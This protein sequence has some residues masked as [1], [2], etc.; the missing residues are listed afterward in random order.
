MSQIGDQQSHWNGQ[1]VT[2]VHDENNGEICPVLTAIGIYLHLMCIDQ[3]DGPLMVA[4]LDKDK[5][6]GY[7]TA[8]KIATMLRK[9][10]RNIHPDLLEEE[11]S[12]FSCHSFCF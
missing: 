11:I 4:T 2:V 1:A 10:A 9:I 7:L 5:K 6:V 12:R 8:N 3:L